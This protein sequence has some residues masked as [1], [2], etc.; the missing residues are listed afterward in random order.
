MFVEHRVK[1]LNAIR[2]VIPFKPQGRHGDL[3]RGSFEDPEEYAE[4][5]SSGVQVGHTTSSST[6]LNGRHWPG[7]LVLRRCYTYGNSNWWICLEPPKLRT[8]IQDLARTVLTVLI[9]PMQHE[10][11]EQVLDIVRVLVLEQHL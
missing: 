7:E 10:R 4:T 2:I 11:S 5:G 1:S 6:K 3:P 9:S 8:C